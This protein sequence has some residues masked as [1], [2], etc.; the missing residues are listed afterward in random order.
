MCGICGI[1]AFSDGFACDEDD[2]RARCATRW[3]TAG[4]TTAGSW[5]DARE[6]RARSAT[7]GCRSSTSRP[8]ATSRCRTRTA[9]SGSPSTARSTTT[10]RCA[11]ELEAQGPRLPL[12]HRHRG[13]RPPLRGG[14]HPLRRAPRRHVRVRDL[15]RAHAASCSSPATGSASSR[16][17]TPQP[18]GGFVF[19]SEIKAL[20]A[21]PAITPDLDEEAFYHYLTFVC[22]PAPLTMFEGIRKLAPAERMLVK[23]DGS[24]VSRRLLVA[25]VAEPRDGGARRDVARTSC[26]ERLLE[27]LRGSIDKRMMADVPFGVFLSGGVD[28][29]TNV[30]LMTRADERPGAHVLGRA[31]S[32]HEQYNEL[33]YAR[34]DRASATAPTTTRSSSTGT[35]SQTFLP[36]MI[37][38]Q[39]EPIAD[40]VCV[41][42]YYVVEA[43]ARQRHDRRP[44]RRGLRRALPRL[45]ELHRRGRAAAGATG[46]R[47]S[48]CPAPLRR[49]AGALG[50]WR[51]RSRTGRGALPRA[52]RRRRGRRAA[53]VLGRRDRL[54]GRHQGPACSPTA[55]CARTPTRSS[56]ASG[57]EAE[58]E[59]PGADLLQKMTYLELKQR[60]AELLLMR[61]DKMTMATSVEAPRAVPRPRARRV[62][63][64]AA[65]RA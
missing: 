50:H 38:H 48:A 56:S 60:L 30:A 9:R 43:R 4:P 54:A 10:P 36:E 35:T 46:S 26:E 8:P 1:L 55:T 64:R 58:R 13:D 61:V 25:D 27:L 59:R 22:T 24:T 51:C 11:P 45:P 41:P 5:T 18:P 65:A 42:L 39:D 17:T 29:S 37:H 47:S 40:W 49:A 14:G 53:A 31:S 3:S 12:A 7:G 63:D 2:R 62:R 28:S 44:G 33:E 19:G 21:H 57:S 32:E 15:G 6:P 23:P 20:L 52:V 16:S 34:R